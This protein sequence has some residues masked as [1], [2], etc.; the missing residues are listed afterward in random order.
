[1]RFG[2]S[3]KGESVEMGTGGQASDQKKSCVLGPGCGK[4]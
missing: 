1:M 2:V 3:R 4:G